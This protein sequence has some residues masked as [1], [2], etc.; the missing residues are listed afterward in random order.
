MNP[1]IQVLLSL[2]TGIVAAYVTAKLSLRQYFSTKW[3]ERKE[4][5]Y[6]EVANALCDMLQYLEVQKE[7][8]GQGTGLPDETEKQLGQTYNDAYWRLRRATTLGSFVL[9]AKA[10]VVLKNLRD[11]PELK[12]GENPRFEIYQHEFTYH[13]EALDKITEI[14]KEDLKV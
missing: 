2:I 6:A 12:W 14:A 4:A 3:W 11:R 8:Y 13:R 5:A 9:S 10:Q 1:W 7:D